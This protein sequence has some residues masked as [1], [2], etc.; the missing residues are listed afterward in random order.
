MTMEKVLIYSFVK[1]SRLDNEE[2][3]LVKEFINKDLK[4]KT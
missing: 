4:N 2:G 3:R 1:C